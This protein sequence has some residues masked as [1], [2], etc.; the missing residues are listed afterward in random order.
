MLPAVSIMDNWRHHI[1][2]VFG[3]ASMF[4]LTLCA[5][6]W[7]FNHSEFVRGV[8]WIYLP[9]GMRLLCTLLFGE[10]GAVGILCASWISCF[11]YYFPTDPVRSFFG[12]ILSALAPWLVYLF[13]KRVLGLHASLSNLTARRL[14]LLIVLYALASPALHQTW[15]ALNGDTTN[16]GERFL[17]MFVGDL[18][19]SLVLIYTLKLGLWFARL[20]AT[21][22]Q[23]G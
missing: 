16:I 9:A 18:C 5:N 23:R 6:E 4:L 3:T 15:L 17:V 19:G 8:N 2:V 20:G 11:F 21:S 22:G 12:G 1:A 13:A 14:L 10:A 7:I